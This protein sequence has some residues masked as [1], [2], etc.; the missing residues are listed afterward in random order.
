MEVLINSSFEFNQN[1]VS[2][3]S[4]SYDC[5]DRCS[6]D[7]SDSCSCDSYCSDW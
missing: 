4:C 2:W 6:Y 3:D 1:N 7:C 5:S